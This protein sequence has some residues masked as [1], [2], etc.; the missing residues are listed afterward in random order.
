MILGSATAQI[1]LQA[2]GGV[3]IAYVD[4][5]L[6]VPIMGP[7]AK[8]SI[9]IGS[10]DGSFPWEGLPLSM[11]ID[12]SYTYATTIGK[13]RYDRSLQGKYLTLGTHI[14]YTLEK[15][16][17]QVGVVFTKSTL[18]GSGP[19][20]DPEVDDAVGIQLALGYELDP[21]LFIQGSIQRYGADL[22][23]FTSPFSRRNA[24]WIYAL[25]CNY[26]IQTK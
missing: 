7:H 20:F 5:N 8:V 3:G 6:W 19:F 18:S 1:S 25:T 4:V 16:H 15:V 17:G 24:S 26:M 11:G 13:E 10:E 22:D 2:K 12:L 23:G 14:G 21:K 9:D